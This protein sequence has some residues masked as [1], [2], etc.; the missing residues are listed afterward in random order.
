MRITRKSM[1]FCIF[2]KYFN[3]RDRKPARRRR[4]DMAAPAAAAAPPMRSGMARR[5]ERST[6]VARTCIALGQPQGSSIETTP[7]AANVIIS[8]NGSAVAPCARVKIPKKAKTATAPRDRRRA[9]TKSKIH[10]LVAIQVIIHFG[11]LLSTPF[12]CAQRITIINK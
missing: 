6:V 3:R 4:I 11:Y 8:K 9:S 7:N 1:I 10:D 5:R 2:S 12:I